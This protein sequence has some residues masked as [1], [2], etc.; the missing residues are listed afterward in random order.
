MTEPSKRSI[1]TLKIDWSNLQSR[2][3]EILTL[4]DISRR[5]PNW[6]KDQIVEALEYMTFLTEMPV[7]CKGN[8]CKYASTCPL[9]KNKTVDRFLEKNCPIEIVEGFRLFAGYVNDLKI[10][11]EDFVDLQHLN[12]LIR[13]H[14]KMRQLDLIAR[15]ETPIEEVV[16]MVGTRQVV[17]RKP[18]STLKA[19]AEIRTDIKEK[20]TALV[21]SRRDKMQ[22]ERDNKGKADAASMFAQL[23]AAGDEE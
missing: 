12:E 19:Q 7:N 6:D 23:L 16:T 21:A 13:L 18:S 9:V 2:P 22:M 14:I 8:D 11:S 17:T 10:K 15:N 5:L 1:P 3:D 4:W 20:Y